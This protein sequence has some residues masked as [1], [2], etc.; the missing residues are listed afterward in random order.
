MGLTL[1]LRCCATESFVGHNCG[2]SQAL[3]PDIVPCFHHLVLA[4]P[5]LEMHEWT[6]RIA[7]DALFPGVI[8]GINSKKKERDTKLLAKT[9]LTRCVGDRL[10]P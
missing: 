1:V 6:D 10:Y 5:H 4:V 7:P 8:T 9:E 3:T 2:W